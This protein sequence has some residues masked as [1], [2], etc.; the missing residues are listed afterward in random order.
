M[1]QHGTFELSSMTQHRPRVSGPCEQCGHDVQDDLVVEFTAPTPDDEPDPWV[2]C[3][4]EE[5]CTARVLDDHR[6]PSVEC[7]TCGA[8][9]KLVD[10]DVLP[11][12]ADCLYN[13]G[14]G[15]VAC[16]TRTLRMV[17]AGNYALGDGQVELG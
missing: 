6:H 10:R 14:E 5:A 2:H 8:Q 3:R 11:S 7:R 13:I 17:A 1:I 12:R 15:P 16:M 9:A 4:D